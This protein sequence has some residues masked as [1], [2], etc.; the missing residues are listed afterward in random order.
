MSSDDD[1]S[2]NYL[3]DRLREQIK[4]EG[5]LTFR[6]WM[7]AALYDERDG[8]YCR[9]DLIRQG[10]AGDYRTA[11]ETSA[12]FAATFANYFAKLYSDLG[13]P[14]HWTIIE[15]GAGSGQFARGV[16]HA[17]Q[18]NFPRIFAATTYLI[19]EISADARLKARANLEQFLDR[20]EFTRLADL[21]EP[22]PHGIIFSNELI[23][24]FPVHRV[25]VRGDALKELCVGVNQ[26]AEFVW[27]ER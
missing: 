1:V 27:V 26:A 25:T 2:P 19:D 6:D 11:P 3:A 15:A 22:L 21:S 17:L 14:A 24:A 23:D 5:P 12:L 13:A 16:L 4:R 18:S 20:V 9:G 10:R 7:Q 8:Y